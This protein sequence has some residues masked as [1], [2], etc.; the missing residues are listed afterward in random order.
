[1]R[2]KWFGVNAAKASTSLEA[3]TIGKSLKTFSAFVRKVR[4]ASSVN[5][6][7]DIR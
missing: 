1:M 6:C 2:I 3:L 7:S 5:V 4:R